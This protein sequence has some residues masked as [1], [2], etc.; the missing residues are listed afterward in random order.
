MAL[1]AS[2]LARRLRLALPLARWS[3][4]SDPSRSHHRRRQQSQAA[5]PLGLAH[6]QLIHSLDRSRLRV[7]FRLITHRQRWRHRDPQCRRR[8]Q[9]LGRP[10][11]RHGRS[12]RSTP[13]WFH[14]AVWATLRLFGGLA[15]RRSRKPKPDR[16]YQPA[17]RRLQVRSLAVTG[18]K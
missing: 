16:F 3:R 7:W 10:D 14:L 6:R 1:R 15:W 17:D 8:P 13:R 9:V 11:V 18:R 4:R 2:P 5:Q 12:P